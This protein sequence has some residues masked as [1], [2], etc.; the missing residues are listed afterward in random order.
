MFQAPLNKKID[1]GSPHGELDC[2][3][4][5][6]LSTQE[7]IYY[8]QGLVFYQVQAWMETLV[9][10]RHQKS[11]SKGGKKGGREGGREEG[12]KDRTFEIAIYFFTSIWYSFS[13]LCFS[14]YYVSSSWHLIV[15]QQ[16]LDG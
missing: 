3:H 7:A 4:Q 13:F 6:L 12:R 9:R 11:E 10:V 14:L 16:I 1:E 5:A 15:A 2:V 8:S